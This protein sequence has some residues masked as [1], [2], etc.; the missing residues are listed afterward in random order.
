[1]P[2]PPQTATAASSRRSY[3]TPI[4]LLLLLV[5]VFVLFFVSESAQRERAHSANMYAESL[6]GLI[7]TGHLR[8][9]IN[10]SFRS[11]RG[12]LLTGDTRFLAPHR[13]AMRR[14]PELADTI[15]EHASDD[16]ED[17]ASAEKLKT[18]SLEILNIIDR[19]LFNAQNGKFEETLA[20]M[21]TGKG[22]IAMDQISGILSR[23]EDA[24]KR[25]V[26]MRQAW[27]QRA[28][29][30]AQLLNRIA[31]ICSLALLLFAL[32]ESLKVRRVQIAMAEKN[33]RLD[34]VAR[35]D[36]LTEVL[37]R[38]GILNEL[39][40]Q[41]DQAELGESVAVAL[42]DIDRFKTIND[43][44]GHPAGDEVLRKVADLLKHESRRRDT[45][46][47]VG[48]EEFLVVMPDTTA[49]QAM[50]ASARLCRLLEKLPVP[51]E[52]NVTLRTTMSG[53]VGAH[54]PGDDASSLLSRADKALYQA[55]R[56][57]RNR[58]LLAA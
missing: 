48:G 9:E 1:M 51:L 26:N 52:G 4:A 30:R 5:A 42:F 39:E 46:G 3:A 23:L 58:V 33:A 13:S 22:R 45:V 8:A 6:E 16:E 34:E 20:L 15:I 53:G 57:G 18:M 25:K 12:Y 32:L 21:R 17:L 31:V 7:A 47:R 37:N 11:A 27:S 56:E 49:D 35:T 29:A 24:E 43:Q 2:Q 10:G 55:K 41:I 19:G 54:E 40:H 36:A 50:L 38:R 14:V 44:H 28:D